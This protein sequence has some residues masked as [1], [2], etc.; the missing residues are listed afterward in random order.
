MTAL[1]TLVVTTALPVLRADIGAT[2][3]N[4]EWIVNAYT[5]AA[6]ERRGICP[7]RGGTR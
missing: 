7:G 6:V 2:L 5:P 1:D 3:T 4:L